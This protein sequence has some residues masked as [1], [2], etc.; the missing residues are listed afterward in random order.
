LTELY[1]NIVS[2]KQQIIIDK[3]LERNKKIHS[4]VINNMIYL[5][6]IRTK[7]DINGMGI[8]GCLPK[9]IVKMIA[10]EVWNT[11]SDKAWIDLFND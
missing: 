1:F 8:I 2:N 11:R 9:D 3:L 7:T 5:I 4:A 6:G 10:K